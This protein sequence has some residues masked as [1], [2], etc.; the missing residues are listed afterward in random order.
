MQSVGM[1]A[2]HPNDAVLDGGDEYFAAA[3]QR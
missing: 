1:K 2:R 3:I